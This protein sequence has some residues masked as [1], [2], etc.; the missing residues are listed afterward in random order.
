[1]KCYFLRHG[2]AFEPQDWRGSEFD[3]PL[4]QEGKEQMQRAAEAI[5][6]MELHF[7]VI[8]SSPLVR[9]KQTAVFVAQALQIESRLNE[10]ARLAPGFDS[11][12]LTAIVGENQ[13][14]AS[15]LFV[16]HEPS[17]GERI[18]DLTGAR[19]KFKK[20]S[21]ALVKIPNPNTLSGILE[22][23]IPAKV[24]VLG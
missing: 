8:L 1:M 3:R 23:L 7:D 5:A 24:L 22:W 4:T 11:A 17:L 15:I 18:R 16:G 21:L 19:V 9:A 6:Q 10:D 2:I 14:A 20:G 12:S 13:D